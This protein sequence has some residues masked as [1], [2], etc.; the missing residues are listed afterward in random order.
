MLELSRLAGRRTV[1]VDAGIAQCL[2]VNAPPA[3]DDISSSIG[4]HTLLRHTFQP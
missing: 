2:G 3:R 1:D 4:Q